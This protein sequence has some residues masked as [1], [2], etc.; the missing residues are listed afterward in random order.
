M[1]TINT[2]EKAHAD[3]MGDFIDE[4][5]LLKDYKP[6]TRQGLADDQL[7]LK[8]FDLLPPNSLLNVTDNLTTDDASLVPT[9]GT[10]AIRLTDKQSDIVGAVFYT[11]NSKVKPIV[12]DP[13]GYG[14]IVIGDFNKANE[15]LA[16]DDLENG[17]DAYAC[18]MASDKTIIVSPQKTNQHLKK[19]VQ[20]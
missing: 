19:M 4:R 17:I 1:T 5:E 18:L 15:V 13:I 7:L 2:H 14:A 12:I 16:F 3:N 6:V 10:I 8:L 20:H 11:P 9:A